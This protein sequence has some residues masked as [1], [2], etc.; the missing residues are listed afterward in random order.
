MGM[1]EVLTENQSNGEFR[2]IHMKIPAHT[3]GVLEFLLFS[4]NIW[5]LGGMNLLSQRHHFI[6]LPTQ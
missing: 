5:W 2:K 4:T 3:F 6:H 1:E